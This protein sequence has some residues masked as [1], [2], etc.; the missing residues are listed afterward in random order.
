MTKR[1]R[2]FRIWRVT[3]RDGRQVTLRGIG[4]EDKAGLHS[5]SGGLVLKIFFGS[6]SCNIAGPAWDCEAQSLLQAAPRAIAAGMEAAPS[7]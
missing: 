3:L 7:M 4:P 2:T 6:R 1:S 5:N